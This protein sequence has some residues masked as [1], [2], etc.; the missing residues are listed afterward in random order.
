MPVANQ[1]CT[2]TGEQCVASSAQQADRDARGQRAHAEV[3]LQLLVR[4]RPRRRDKS[5]RERRTARARRGRPRS[6]T[7]PATGARSRRRPGRA[8]REC[9]PRRW[10][11]RS[12]R[13]EAARSGSQARRSNP[14]AI[15]P[16][17]CESRQHRRPPRHLPGPLEGFPHPPAKDS[18][19]QAE[20]RPRDCSCETRTP[21]R[22]TPPRR[23]TASAARAAT[24]RARRTP[25]GNAAVKITTTTRISQTWLALPDGTYR[26]LDRL[27]LARPTRPERQQVPDAA[28]KIGASQDHV[29]H[30]RDDDDAG[31]QN[32]RR[33]G[34]VPVRK[35]RPD[36]S[37]RSDAK[38][39][40]RRLCRERDR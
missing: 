27:A 10:R 14:S 34:Q 16:G 11:P 32:L 37:R 40:R 28:A 31:E 39:D 21:I 17:R 19:R 26:V 5:P 7:A 22:E 18:A 1:R 36:G 12:S 8:R 13:A 33:H 20:L 9:A 29:E 38:A 15:A 30:E 24:S 4:P 6:E 3:A 23:E 25:S 35:R 2:A